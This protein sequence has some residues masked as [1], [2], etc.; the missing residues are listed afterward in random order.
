MFEA[1]DR[2]EALERMLEHMVL[3]AVPFAEMAYSEP[4]NAADNWVASATYFR[5][6]GN[7]V[8]AASA[9]LSKQEIPA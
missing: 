3:C 7:A 5:A 6:M 4:D 9:L 1:A 8:T 2:I